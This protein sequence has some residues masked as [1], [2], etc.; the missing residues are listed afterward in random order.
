MAA[1]PKNPAESN[2]H[3]VLQGMETLEEILSR[4][5]TIEELESVLQDYVDNLD[6]IG[7]LEEAE[8]TQVALAREKVNMLLTNPDQY[9]LRGG[10]KKK[11]RRG[12]KR[13]EQQLRAAESRGAKE[14]RPSTDQVLKNIDEL[15]GEVAAEEKEET[16][17]APE[18]MEEEEFKEAVQK[19]EAQELE[20]LIADLEQKKKQIDE[21]R[22]S[23]ETDLELAQETLR[24]KTGAPEAMTIED[25]L[26]E[27]VKDK[28]EAKK[29]YIKIAQLQELDATGSEKIEKIQ[30]Q[31]EAILNTYRKIKPAEL[32]SKTI[33]KGLLENLINKLKGFEPQI[34]AVL[35]SKKRAPSKP[36]PPPPGAFA[37]PPPS[38]GEP[39][40][41]PEKETTPSDDTAETSGDAVETVLEPS[42]EKE[43]TEEPEPAPETATTTPEKGINKPVRNLLE[44]ILT[45]K[46][47]VRNDSPVC[48]AINALV[49]NNQINLKKLKIFLQNPEFLR[50]NIDEDKIEAERKKQGASDYEALLQ[51]LEDE[52]DQNR[53]YLDSIKGQMRLS[54]DEIAKRSKAL[55]RISEI[56]QLMRETNSLIKLKGRTMTYDSPR[57][58]LAL[59]NFYLHKNDTDMPI[60]TFGAEIERQVNEQKEALYSGKRAT[61]NR[62]GFFLR[63]TLKATLKT[64]AKDRE[65]ARLGEKP[66]DELAKLAGVFGNS[67]DKVRQWIEDLPGGFE[68]HIKTTVPRL[69]AYLELAIRDGNVSRLFKTSRARDLVRHLK[70]IQQDYIKEEVEEEFR[71][72]PSMTN[73]GKMLLYL[74]KLNQS[75]RHTLDINKK[76]LSRNVLKSVS[77]KGLTGAGLGAAAVLSPLPFLA[78]LPAFLAAPTFVASYTHRVP[79][80][81]RGTV[82]K[83]TLRAAVANGLAIGGAALGTLFTGGM[84]LPLVLGTLGAGAGAMS[85][86]IGKKVWKEK[87]K[88]GAGGVTVA[89]KIPGMAASTVKGGAKVLK[90]T[91]GLPAVGVWRGTMWTLGKIFK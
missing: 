5:H 46:E 54:Q 23:I 32:K 12:L 10:Q 42:Q 55:D 60:E 25:A 14:E 64:L 88:I 70:N 72:N 81:H 66:E 29:L 56:K 41:E 67:P 80:K 74:Q 76:I 61:I 90:W 79:E 87:R 39:E 59:V 30:K 47:L 33:L 77:V 65:F 20:S 17:P 4:D 69:I 73:Q 91:V 3:P 16:E 52:L 15:L 71:K 48:L 75:T 89:K 36:P 21:E 1:Q 26:E 49:S 45:K 13:A 40:N 2:K 9:G 85:P 19:M 35:K 6:R 53:N 63:P 82:K 34:D 28:P 78:T 57:H 68:K 22:K 24:Q 51:K 83:A 58:V 38:M 62:F 50:K 86:E 37:T 27:Y 43:K 18:P 8:K 11:I 84:A 7:F 31:L 44:S